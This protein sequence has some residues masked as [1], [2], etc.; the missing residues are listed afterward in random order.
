MKTF[1][2]LLVA[3]L[4]GLGL[5]SY[6]NP[7]FVH[8]AQQ[9]GSKLLG[10][11]APAARLYKWRDAQGQWQITDQL[12]AAGTPYETLEYRHDLNVLPVP[13]QLQEP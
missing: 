6:Y 13:P 10:T 4:V 11:P 12:P 1:L 2:Y 8:Q 9:T 3:A 7:T 5:Y